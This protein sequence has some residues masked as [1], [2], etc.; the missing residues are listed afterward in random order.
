MLLLLFL[1]CCKV[2]RFFKGCFLRVVG[3]FG[4][5]LFFVVVVFVFK[6]VGIFFVRVVR[7]VKKR[8]VMNEI[9]EESNY[10]TGDSF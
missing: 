10:G 2:E 9:Y 6:L 1:R 3:L 8:N 7:A 4:T 5:L